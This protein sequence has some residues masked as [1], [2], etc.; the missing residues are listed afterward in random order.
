MALPPLDDALYSRCS[1][2]PRVSLVIPKA[3]PS[4]LEKAYPFF[5]L[6]LSSKSPLCLYMVFNLSNNLNKIVTT[7]W[8]SLISGFPFSVLL[9]QWWTELPSAHKGHRLEALL[10]SQATLIFRSTA[11]ASPSS[12]P[13]SSHTT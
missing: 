10:Q 4:S 13:L 9:L 12:K 6:P 5:W 11:H 2:V 7:L 1:T 3:I 8:P